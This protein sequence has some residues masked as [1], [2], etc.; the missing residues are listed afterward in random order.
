VCAAAFAAGWSCLLFIFYL[1]PC[2][3]SSI[4]ALL[5]ADGRSQQE[6]TIEQEPMVDPN[7]SRRLILARVDGPN[8]RIRDGSTLSGSGVRHRLAAIFRHHLAWKGRLMHRIVRLVPFNDQGAILGARQLWKT[9]APNQCRF[10]IWL[11]LLGR[12]WTSERL[13][14]HGLCNNGPCVQCS[15][16]TESL[17]HLLAQCVFSREVWFR[18]LQRCGWQHLSP[19]RQARWVD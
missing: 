4:R 10:Y 12:C 2:V 15:Q 9:R 17:D 11:V 7:K 8:R 1:R 13:Q 14:H 19:T 3:R 6:P 16:E 18:V 5:R